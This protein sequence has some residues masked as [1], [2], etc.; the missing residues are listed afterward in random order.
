MKIDDLR[1]VGCGSGNIAELTDDQHQFLC[2]DCN[3]SYEV[4]LGVPYFGEFEGDDILG[5]LEI[6]ANIQNRGKFG[7]NP[8]VVENWERLLE[9]YHVATDKPAF[10]QTLS[11]GEAPFVGNRYGEWVEVHLLA[12]GLELAGSQ[13]LDMGA[14]LG[15]DSHRLTMK[16]AEVTALEFSPVL[17][18]AGAQNFPHIRW[19]GGFSH[20]LPFKNASFDA[21]FCNAALHHMRDIPAAISEA[22]RVLK[23]GGVLITTCDSFRPSNSADD[24]E[25]D[26][27]NAEPS[28]L[29][30]VNE[31]VPRF[32]E[33][34]AAQRQHLEKLGIE[35]YTHTL[36]NA[37]SG[38]T[39]S[40]LTRW[41]LDTDGKMLA[42]RSG[43]LAMKVTLRDT[44]PEAPRLQRDG[45]LSAKTYSLW[46]ESEAVAFA[47]L[48]RLMPQKYVDLDFPG[49]RGSKFE[50]LNGWR[51]QQPNQYAR[52]AYR[53]GRW[54]FT[55]K[56]NCDAL[57]FE[58]GIVGS[59]SATPKILDIVLA[60]NHY[61]S[62]P[63]T[64]G[65]AWATVQIDLS[66]ITPEGKIFA[67]ELRLQDCAGGALDECSFTVRNRRF[68]AYR[69]GPGNV[70]D[71]AVM[72]DD[73]TVYAVIPVF[74][75][76]NYTRTCIQNLKAQ[77]YPRMVIIVADGGST[78]GTVETIRAE[79]PDVVV[80]TATQELWWSGSMAMGIDYALGQSKGAGDAILMMNNDT[81]IPSD[82]VATLAKAAGEFN[83]AVGG[84]IVDSRDPSV[85]LDAGEFIDW[86][87]YSFPVKNNVFPEERFCAGV[88]VLPGR[89][90]LVPIRMIRA[91]GNVDAVHLPHYLADYEFFYRLKQCGFNLGVCYETRLLA[92]IEETGLVPTLG[93]ATF[94]TI[95]AELFSRRSM[96]NVVDHWFFVGKHAPDEFRW[97]LRA[98][99]IKRVLAELTLRTA[100][101]PV[102]LPLYYLLLSPRIL[103]GKLRGQARAFKHFYVAW[104]GQGASV[105][106]EPRLIPGLIRIPLFLLASPGPLCEGDL[107]RTGGSAKALVDAGV[108]SNLAVA[109]WYKLRSL[110]FAKS[111]NPGVH[112]SLYWQA[113]NPLRKIARSLAYRRALLEAV[114]NG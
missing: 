76:L 48:A 78:D 93:A 67:V 101:R 58:A 63:L 56:E 24:A 45:I 9:A 28:V 82:Y 91:A 84:L 14:G 69:N 70:P 50:L 71:E 98:R 75:R 104:R 109:G 10:V 107:A 5:L 18:E 38:G 103:K 95:W 17:A 22:L 68:V 15:F 4:V 16:G 27:F 110:D 89:G 35:V 64:P 59:S 49:G 85:V 66:G 99:L 102:F 73:G 92:H 6:A 12:E 51:N 47:E 80:L 86:K 111:G 30:G 52:T 87:T 2:L 31:G 55:R 43:S 41:N 34:F 19:I 11:A 20:C 37:P 61:G 60:G 29:M 114:R 42:C 7:V 97:A 13:V 94:K 100:L 106:C 81:E 88:D 90:T 65:G 54:F 79:F 72:A 108:L 83:A 3:K 25:L 21:V 113:W 77:T 74:N 57:L 33:F 26:I 40:D 46:L 96:S 112:K 53:R 62:V 105:L 39:L 44:W 8:Q 36:Y 23:P 1:C 32:S